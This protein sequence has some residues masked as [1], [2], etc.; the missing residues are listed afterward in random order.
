MERRDL[1]KILKT[2]RI[3]QT[4]YIEEDSNENFYFIAGYTDNGA[5]YG[6]TW[7]EYISNNLS[8]R[9]AQREDALIAAEL[10]HLAIHDIAEQLTGEEKT[11]K[12][13]EILADFF[14]SE[15]NRLSYQ[16]T[17]VAD[18]EGEVAGIV[19]TYLGEDAG[20][21]DE[22]ILERLR[23][24]GKQ[25]DISLDKEA[26]EGDFYIDTVCVHSDFRGHGIGTELLKEA[27]RLAMKK[28]YE[29]VSL[30]VANDNPSAQKLYKSLGYIVEK[31][32]QI[33]GHPYDYMVKTLK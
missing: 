7:E 21:L 24:K 28:G 12:I 31:T 1:Q 32:I 3:E 9:P 15:E 23:E 6:V 22:P 20:R 29:R 19:L 27:E 30:N 16:N 25:L 18:I 26:D 8:F 17:L 2:N 14:R 5:A 11:E 33:N 4:N 10:M 13:R